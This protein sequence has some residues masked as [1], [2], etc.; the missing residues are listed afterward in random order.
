MATEKQLHDAFLNFSVTYL[1][2]EE[3]DPRVVDSIAKY[4]LKIDVS[5]FSVP[6]QPAGSV[7]EKKLEE[8]KRKHGKTE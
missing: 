5:S 1:N 7:G 6:D 8:L 2:G 3:Q 4:L